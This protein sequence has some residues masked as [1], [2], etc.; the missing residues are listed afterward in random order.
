MASWRQNVVR[1]SYQYIDNGTDKQKTGVYAI[2]TRG[3]AYAYLENGI[4]VDDVPFE[5]N[6]TTV[7][8]GPCGYMA[9][10]RDFVA[11]KSYAWM[12]IAG[13]VILS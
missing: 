7:T 8:A 3:G 6:E 2:A 10:T 13:D 5:I 4:G 11:N 9:G 12:C 1:M